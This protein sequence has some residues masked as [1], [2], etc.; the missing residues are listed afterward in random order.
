[1]RSIVLGTGDEEA[2]PR[3]RCLRGSATC[4]GFP[5]YQAPIVSPSRGLGVRRPDTQA[6]GDKPPAARGAWVSRCPRT[7][8]IRGG[9]RLSP[10][11]PLAGQRSVPSF[12][13][14]LDC[15]FK[16]PDGCTGQG[17]FSSENPCATRDSYTQEVSAKASV[18]GM[19]VTHLEPTGA[20]GGGPVSSA[21][22]G[23]VRTTRH[24]RP[25]PRRSR[26]RRLRQPCRTGPG[27]GRAGRPDRRR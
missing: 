6:L 10:A 11:S 5:G 9:R 18:R 13:R 21:A 14:L 23:A 1:V 4:A 8:L 12:V 19:G 15:A 20:P 22:G 3:R 2:E 7:E 17:T 16:A 26:S 25:R 24:R 27:C